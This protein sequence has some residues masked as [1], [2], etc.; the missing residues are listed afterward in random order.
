[1]AYHQLAVN[2]HSLRLL[3]FECLKVLLP[4]RP[5]F[6]SLKSGATNW[7]P[8]ADSSVGAWLCLLLNT[9]NGLIVTETISFSPAW[10]CCWDNLMAEGPLCGDGYCRWV[11]CAVSAG[12][13]LGS[14]K[15][16]L[17]GK[18]IG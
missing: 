10:Q 16:Y 8:V 1:V 7:F 4:K 9:M 17:S 11:P 15:A 18:G 2:P 3:I 13:E 5:R 14:Y 12:A 6:S